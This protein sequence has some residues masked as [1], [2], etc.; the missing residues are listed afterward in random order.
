MILPQASIDI[1]KDWMVRITFL[2]MS[3]NTN[4]SQ[5]R[6]ELVKDLKVGEVLLSSIDYDGSAKATSIYF[7][8]F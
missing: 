8:I 5:R 3:Y 6:T 7:Q 1:K 2:K 4:I